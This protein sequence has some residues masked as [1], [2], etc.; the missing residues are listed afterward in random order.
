MN[1]SAKSTPRRVSSEPFVTS[2]IP[3]Q[4]RDVRQALP[5][6]WGNP[7][8]LHCTDLVLVMASLCMEGCQPATHDAAW[9]TYTVC[10]EPC[11]VHCKGRDF[12]PCHTATGQQAL[13][14]SETHT[15]AIQ[16]PMCMLPTVRQTQIGTGQML[17]CSA[18]GI[19][20]PRQV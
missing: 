19:H 14:I 18:C 5:C 20:V 8:L 9:R 15:L 3:A 4:Y 2:S 10:A 17:R 16:A 1:L 13:C 6:C 12:P 7:R 11:M